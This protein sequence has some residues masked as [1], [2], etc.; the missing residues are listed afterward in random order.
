MGAGEGNA[1]FSVLIRALERAAGQS[2]K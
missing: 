2:V 1:D